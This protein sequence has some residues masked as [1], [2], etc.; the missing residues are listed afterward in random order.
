VEAKPMIAEVAK[1]RSD[2]A[3]KANLKQGTVKPRGSETRATGKTDNSSKTNYVVAAKFGVGHMAIAEGQKVKDAAPEV[4][5]FDCRENC[6]DY[7]QRHVGMGWYGQ[8]LR[9]ANTTTYDCVSPCLS[10]LLWSAKPLCVGSIP[11]RASIFH[12]MQ[13]Q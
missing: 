7:V 2:A 4:F 9:V 8:R 3:G 10:G 12:P 13:N 6:R 11:T 1:K 5:H